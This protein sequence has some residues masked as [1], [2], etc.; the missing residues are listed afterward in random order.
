MSG[1]TSQPSAK[2]LLDL[3]HLR[4]DVRQHLVKVYAVLG[5]MIGASAV[6]AYMGIHHQL[7]MNIAGL[8]TFVTLI[9]LI[10]VPYQHGKVQYE[11]LGLILAFGFFK[12]A[13]LAPLIAHTLHFNPQVLT[14]AFSATCLV[15]GCFTAAALLSNRREYLYLGGFLGGALT[16]SLYLSLFNM[17]IGS[18]AIPWLNI[19]GGVIIFSLYILYDSQMIVEK[20]SMGNYDHVNHALELFLDFIALFVRLLIILNKNANDKKKKKRSD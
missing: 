9:A 19:Y 2:T 8:M 14:L 4:S 18:T 5:A 16:I 12:G 6:G 11:R 3:S 15:F 17:F 7:S 13:T 20:A 1:N 10:F